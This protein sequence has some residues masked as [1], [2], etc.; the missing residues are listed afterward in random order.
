MQ[1]TEPYFSIIVP[2]RNRPQALRRL[3]RSLC[4]LDYPAS[5]FEV[6]VVWDTGSPCPDDIV[7]RFRGRLNVHSLEARHRGPGPAR[8]DGI[9][10]ARGACVALIDDDCEPH[11]DWLRSLALALE[12]DD[13]VAVGGKVLN[14]LT[15]NVFSGASQLLID[16]VYAFCNAD[17]GQ[18]RFFTTNNVAVS[19]RCLHEMGGF[20]RDWTI[21]GA[22]DRDFW[23]RWRQAGFRMLYD[24]QIVVEHAHPMTWK[25]FL[26]THYRY[27]QGAYYF[28][29]RY[30][31]ARSD[32]GPF[33]RGLPAF[34][35]R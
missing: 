35:F 14:K 25:S 7:H 34:V 12:Q 11:Q 8:Q 33:L 21:A 16:Y 28:H 18:A 31:S 3:L 26:G 9:D 27:G 20:D 10:R 1:D 13:A 30:P 15:R 32:S 5:R 4:S 29:R 24:S 17:P 23:M 22:E 2:T 6:I 19:A